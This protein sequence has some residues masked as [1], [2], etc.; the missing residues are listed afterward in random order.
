MAEGLM[1]ELPELLDWRR[2]P[3]ETT[4][5]IWSDLGEDLDRETAAQLSRI[6]ARRQRCL[7]RTNGGTAA[8]GSWRPPLRSRL[9]APRA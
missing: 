6:T 4:E 3:E 5:K 9:A 8:A 1:Q 7:A 2:R